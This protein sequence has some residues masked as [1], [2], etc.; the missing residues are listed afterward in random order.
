MDGN[1]VRI[2]NRYL[3]IYT[4]LLQH[5]LINH[6][7]TMETIQQIEDGIR[8]LSSQYNN[9]NINSRQS[10]RNT[11]RNNDNILNE[12]LRSI[13]NSFA[14]NTGSTTRNVNEDTIPR[15]NRRNNSTNRNSR[16]RTYTRNTDNT[17]TR[18]ST[19]LPQRRNNYMN[20]GAFPLFTTFGPVNYDNLTP[21]TI[22]PNANEINNATEII[23]YSTD[24]THTVCPI[25]Q[26]PFEENHQI[27]RIIHC[28]HCFM[29]DSLNNWFT[30][31][32]LCPVCRYD[33]R[34]YVSPR[35][36]DDTNDD[37]NNNDVSDNDIND[38]SNNTTNNNTRNT[39]NSSSF[40]TEFTNQISDTMLQYLSNSDISLNTT[41]DRGLNIE[42]TIQT[43]NEAFTFSTETP[44]TVDEFFRNFENTY[45]NNT[46]ERNTFN[47]SESEIESE[48]ENEN[49]NDN[50]NDNDDLL[51]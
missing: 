38:N 30:R 25:T 51:S 48:N 41:G 47:E 28:G 45:N 31:S 21:V 42:Y 8:L 37:T 19:I 18:N 32:V 34:S 44:R 29:N 26:S 13:Y 20:T 7:Q 24:M 14:S 33:I 4:L 15:T 40:L 5:T 10:H 27:R 49:D 39:T 50:D 6:N 43:P 1:S 23:A 46:S 2:Q 36:N 3:D 16:F 17:S 12:S 22:R 35:T 9:T 11:N